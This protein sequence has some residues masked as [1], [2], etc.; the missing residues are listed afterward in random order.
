MIVE[1][2]LAYTTT[3]SI[4]IGLAGVGLSSASAAGAF[5][6]SP[7]IPTPEDPAVR[8]ARLAQ[9]FAAARSRGRQS[10][11]LAGPGGVAEGASSVS[12]PRATGPGGTGG[13]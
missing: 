7:D 1:A 13:L 5:D 3:A 10:T 4:I 11:I 8:K 6:K 9:R 2:T 12:T